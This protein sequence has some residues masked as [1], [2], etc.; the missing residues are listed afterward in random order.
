MSRFLPLLVL[1]PLLACQTQSYAEN[2]P[3]FRIPVGSTVEVRQALT[4]PANTARVYIQ[5]GKTTQYQ[6][7]DQYEANCWVLSW[8]L[9]PENQTIKPGNFIVTRLRELEDLV[10]YKNDMQFVRIKNSPYQNMNG[11]VTAVE[12]KTELTIHS[13]EQPDIRKLVCNH[14]EDPSDA[15]HL[16]LAEIRTTLGDL[17]TIKLKN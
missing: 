12:Y 1:L 7:L 15:R 3:Y 14:W 4:I 9:V 6:K 16:S 5:Y 13:S 10:R 8:K 11:G 2:S 17:I